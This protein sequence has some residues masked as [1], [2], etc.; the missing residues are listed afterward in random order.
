MDIDNIR[1]QQIA[2][3]INSL[4]DKASGELTVK[5]EVPVIWDGTCWVI[6]GGLPVL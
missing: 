2:D 4:G 3:L 1:R 6:E 5:T